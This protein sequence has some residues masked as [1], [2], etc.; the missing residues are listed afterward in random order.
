MKKT[1]VSWTDVENQTQEILRKVTSKEGDKPNFSADRKL[2]FGKTLFAEES[3]GP[4][5]YIY[6]ANKN[7]PIYAYSSTKIDNVDQDKVV[8]NFDGGIGF[9]PA[10]PAGT[11]LKF[12]E[13]SYDAIP[14]LT[15]KP[16]LRIC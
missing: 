10:P 2:A 15:A 4:Y 11:P 9:A 8:M 12:S 1:L 3:K 5:K 7:G 6:S 16:L 13:K 14:Y